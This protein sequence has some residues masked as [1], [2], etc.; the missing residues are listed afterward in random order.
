MY[1]YTPFY[2]NTH[3]TTTMTIS[4]CFTVITN[5]IAETP[6]NDIPKGICRWNKPFHLV[7][8]DQLPYSHLH[9]MMYANISFFTYTST[10]T[11]DAILHVDDM[12]D[13]SPYPIK[14]TFDCFR[15]NECPQSEPLIGFVDG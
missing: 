8:R 12:D 11:F 3:T 5:C 7:Q 1:I 9:Y 14:Y 10:A 2:S 6:A 4:H 15:M 13:F